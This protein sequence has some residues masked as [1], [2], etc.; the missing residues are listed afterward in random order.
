MSPGLPSLSPAA[1]RPR[2]TMSGCS[3]ASC[4]SALS[5][6]LCPVP[7]G[8]GHAISCVS[9]PRPQPQC[10]VLPLFLGAGECLE[11]HR[12]DS[13]SPSPSHHPVPWGWDA[14]CPGCPHSHPPCPR[15]CPLGKS[16]MGT[17]HA[18]VVPRPHPCPQ[19]W[20][21]SPGLGTCRAW[22]VPRPRPQHR[23][24]S[25]GGAGEVPRPGCPQPHAPVPVPSTR[26]CPASSLTS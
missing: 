10:L 9:C 16:S 17:R 14:P 24:V 18:W 25:P 11:C 15:S 26:S 4:P 20:V 6:T 8:L 19:H 7:H 1:P 12:S 13:L 5:P 22:G 3:R 23:V 21:L 2:Y